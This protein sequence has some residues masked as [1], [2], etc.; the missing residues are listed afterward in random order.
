M[1]WLE[2]VSVAENFASSTFHEWCMEFAG[3]YADELMECIKFSVSSVTHTKD[4]L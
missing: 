1:P 4:E 3:L 2:K